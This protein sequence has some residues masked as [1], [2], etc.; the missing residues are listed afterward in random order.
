MEAAEIRERVI[1]AGKKTKRFKALGK[2]KGREDPKYTDEENLEESGAITKVDAEFLWAFILERKPKV[3]V[4]IGT[5][6]GTSAAVMAKAQSTYTDDGRVYTCDKHNVYV[7]DNP[8]VRYSNCGSTRF[9]EKMIRNRV[10]AGMV[11]TDARLKLRDIPLLMDV[12]RKPRLF[13]T[14]DYNDSK[15]RSNI[16]LVKPVVISKTP[17][18]LYRA[19]SSTSDTSQ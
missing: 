17:R 6:F 9:L 5:W 7:L 18:V 8:K 19:A 1:R 13:L 12:M 11:F 15:G 16:K 14:H 4:E 10:R 2:A 3:I